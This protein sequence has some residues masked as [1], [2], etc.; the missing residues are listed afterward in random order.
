MVDLCRISFLAVIVASSLVLPACDQ[1]P[2]GIT[3]KPDG[4]VDYYDQGGGI[5]LITGGDDGNDSDG[6]TISNQGIETCDS[7]DNDCNGT[8]D[9]VAGSTLSN[10][11]QNCGSCGNTCYF[12]NAFAKC[13]NS[14]CVLDSCAPG[15]H[16]L[17]PNDGKGC[18]YQCLPS[19]G[20]A[21][22]CPP[23]QPD[24]SCDGVDNDCDGQ[25]DEVFD[26]NTDINNCGTC[27]NRC[28]YNNAPG[29]CENGVCKML[30]CNPGYKD[31]DG[32]PGCEY[33]CPIFPPLTVDDNCDGIDGNCDGVADE[34]FA[35]TP[36]GI[37]T[38]ECQKGTTGCSGGAVVCQGAIDPT[39]ELCD[40]KDNNCDGNDDEIFD[41]QNDPRYC[42]ASCVKCAFAHAI[43]GCKNGSCY[44][45]VCEVG[46]MNRDGQD[47]TGCEYPCSPTGAEICD[48]L[49]NDCNGLIDA[50]DPAMVPLASNPCVQHGLCSGATASCQGAAGWVCNFGAG[51]ELKAC[52][53]SAD[54]NGHPCNA[55]ACTGI[56]ADEETL[57]DDKDN[58]CDGLT[59]ESFSQKG[60]VCVEAAK[61]GICQGTGTF[62]CTQDTLSTT[63]DITT[64]GLTA[65]DEVCNG[66]DD[67]CDGLTDEEADD[68]AG[69]GVVDTMVHIVSTFDNGTGSQTYDFWM[70]T[71]EASKPDANASAAGTIV[72]R[73]CSKSNVV[74]WNNVNYTDA[75]AACAA[76][77]KRLCTATEWFLACSGAP[78]TDTTTCN[79]TTGDGCYYPY[80]DTYVGATCNG[81][82]YDGD[83]VNAG[84]QD[85][86]LNTGAA[87]SCVSTHLVYDLSGNLREWTDDPR[88]DGTPPDPDGYTVRGGAY[89]TPQGGLRCDD[90]FAVMPETFIFP[91]LGFRCCSDSAP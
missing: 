56:L 15:F 78:T 29:S 17:Q 2:Y 22:E 36:C 63:C 41:K 65:T 40:G 62:V 13:E 54:C 35:A 14:K 6:C 64:P 66:L 47:S 80:G 77:G 3:I 8:V 38:G 86:L 87:A 58:D 45:A 44:I 21:E 10:D 23:A 59:D 5:D 90:T 12:P 85:V 50:A 43:P 76:A 82:E 46:Y 89:D 42:G 73:A 16:D 69:K 37:D 48:G 39:V 19:S 30:A 7:Q 72:S 52:T 4:F 20:G 74:P 11:P 60:A 32:S 71:Y 9:D 79:T 24:C 1:D 68:A 91:N 83:P 70:Y 51:V 53:T 34:G 31:I 61:N 55:S 88:S 28:V 49:D 81:Q 57:C 33:K 84:D 27:G 67:D 18:E 26:K 75:D 25:I